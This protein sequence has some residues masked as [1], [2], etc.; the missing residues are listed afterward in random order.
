MSGSRSFDPSRPL[1]LLSP[2]FDDAA[3]SCAALLARSAPVDVLTVFGGEPEP[4]RRGWWD[5][6]CGFASSTEGLAARRREEQSAF[7]DSQHRVTWLSLLEFQYVQ[8]PRPQ[9]ER[10]VIL[11]AVR[12]WS[13][14]AGNETVAIPAGAGRKLGRVALRLAALAPG[15]LG[16]LQNPDHVFVRDAALAA[17]RERPSLTGLIYEELPYLWSVPAD[18]EVRAAA[19]E[20]SFAAEPFAI[21]VDRG[22]KARVNAAYESQVTGLSTRRLR[23]DDPECLPEVERYWSLARR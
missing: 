12:E 7:A 21:P 9:K 2:H 14:R 11:E 18:E 10:A 13:S 5:R 6:E 23:L 1:L 17:L 8:G 3:F 4:P 19:A 22:E 15:R 16:F 20:W